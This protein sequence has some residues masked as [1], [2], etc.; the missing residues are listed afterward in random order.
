MT[1]DEANKTEGVYEVLDAFD[2]SVKENLCAS[3][4]HK[5]DCNAREILANNWDCDNVVECK[6]YEDGI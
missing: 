1:F 4:I 5:F 2:I 6:F 3:C